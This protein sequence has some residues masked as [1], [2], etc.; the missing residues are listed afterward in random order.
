MLTLEV[1]DMTCGHCAGRISKAVKDLDPEATVAIDLAQRQV[2]VSPAE[3]TP[4]AIRE[5][6]V[7]A[8]YTPRAIA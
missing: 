6:I 2:S 3:A 5:A 4:E 1:N 7:A 8:G